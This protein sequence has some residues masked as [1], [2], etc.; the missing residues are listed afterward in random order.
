MDKSCFTASRNINTHLDCNAY[1]PNC[2]V[3]RFKD[4]NTNEFIIG[5]C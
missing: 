2:T 5:G 3:S 1:F 4:P